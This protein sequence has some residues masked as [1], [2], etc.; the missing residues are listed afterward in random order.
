MVVDKL[1]EDSKQIPERSL[2]PSVDRLLAD[3]EFRKHCCRTR[4]S[5]PEIRTQSESQHRTGKKD[6]RHRR[7]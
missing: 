4:K 6:R 1:C 3:F 2:R 5:S 7:L